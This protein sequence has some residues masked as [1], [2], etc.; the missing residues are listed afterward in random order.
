MGAGLPRAVTGC[1]WEPARCCS[2]LRP[3]PPPRPHLHFPCQLPAPIQTCRQHTA[4]A[5]SR[6]TL[7]FAA[8]SAAAPPASPTGCCSTPAAPRAPSRLRTGAAGRVALVSEALAARTTSPVSTALPLLAGSADP[9]ASRLPSRHSCAA[10]AASQLA[11][12]TTP[13]SIPSPASGPKEFHPGA[14]TARPHNNSSPSSG[15]CAMRAASHSSPLPLVSGRPARKAWRRMKSGVGGRWPPSPPPPSCARTT[16]QQ[17]RARRAGGSMTGGG[18]SVGWAAGNLWR[19]AGQPG[20]RAKALGAPALLVHKRRPG[21]RSMRCMTRSA[22]QQAAVRMGANDFVLRSGEAAA[23]PAPAAALHSPHRNG[24]AQQAERVGCLLLW[25]PPRLERVPG[26][27]HGATAPGRAAATRRGGRAVMDQP[28][29]GWG[30]RMLRGCPAGRL[31][32]V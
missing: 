21:S 2:G 30:K 20:S 10:R 3:P 23:A 1:L 27:M 17:G 7:R 8:A 13:Y 25:A 14:K 31:G 12:P 5:G 18:G 15:C 4:S 16:L 22:A 28:G 6:L 26:D 24:R 9:P 11:D 19:A 32:C 29:A